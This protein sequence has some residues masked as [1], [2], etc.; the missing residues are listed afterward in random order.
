MEIEISL[1]EALIE[2]YKGKNIDIKFVVDFELKAVGVVNIKYNE[3]E[4]QYCFVVPVDNTLIIKDDIFLM[5]YVYDV[6]SPSNVVLI[7]TGER[8]ADL[9]EAVEFYFEE[10]NRDYL[11]FNNPLSK[12]NRKFD[13]VKLNKYKR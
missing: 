3:S 13:R 5:E 12:K 10:P 9:H 2:F 1:R 11:K 6:F 7:T 4:I 8:R